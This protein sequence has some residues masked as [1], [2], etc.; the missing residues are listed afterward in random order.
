VILYEVHVLARQPIR[1]PVPAP[2]RATER[3]RQAIPRTGGAEERARQ[4]LLEHPDIAAWIRRIALVLTV[5]AVVVA[6]VAVIDPVPGDEV[7][8]FAFASALLRFAT[9]R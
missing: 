5:A 1:V 7:A 6:I 4:F 8:A 3:I 2:E 9:Q